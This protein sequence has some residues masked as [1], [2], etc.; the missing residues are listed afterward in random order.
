MDKGDFNW[1]LEC[2]TPKHWQKY[3]T[4]I[5]QTQQRE[6]GFNKLEDQCAIN[7]NNPSNNFLKL[8]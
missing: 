1:G 6:L 8:E 7:K 3:T 2:A 5:Y 4:G